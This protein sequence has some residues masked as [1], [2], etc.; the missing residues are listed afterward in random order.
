MPNKDQR[1]GSGNSVNDPKRASEMG[2]KGGE[3]SGQRQQ[4]QASERSPQQGSQ[5][6]N[7]DMPPKGGQR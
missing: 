1:G 7:R 3:P 6:K 5:H 2:K 4:S